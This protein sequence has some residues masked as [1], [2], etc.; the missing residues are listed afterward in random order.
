[1]CRIFEEYGDERVAERNIE[2]VE[3]LLQQNKLSL[4]EIS[5]VA[6]VPLEH[7]AIQPAAVAAKVLL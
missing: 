1:M 7:V 5:A 6:K 3:A 4:E 2:F